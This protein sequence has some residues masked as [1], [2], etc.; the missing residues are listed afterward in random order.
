M[1]TDKS[2]TGRIEQLEKELTDKKRELA[3]LKQSRFNEQVKDYSLKGP[4]GTTKYL[5]DMFGSSNELIVIHNM[6]KGCP[7]CTLWADGFNGVLDHFENRAGFVVV[8]PDDPLTQQS[9]AKSRGWKFKMFSGEGSNFI[10]DMGFLSDDGSSMPG[11]SIFRK[12][13]KGQIYRTS[14]DFFGPHDNYSGIWHIFDLLPNG[15]NDWEP[16]FKYV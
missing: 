6:G 8:S 2:N 1:N 11:L 14:K 9:F 16:K 3:E 10:K 5:S 7:Y 13:E 4:G 12:D 15:I